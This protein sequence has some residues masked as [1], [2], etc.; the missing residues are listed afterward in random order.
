MQLPKLYLQA[1]RD[2]AIRRFHPWVFSGAI[3]RYEG[4]LSDGD[5]VAIDG[6]SLQ[7]L[8]AAFDAG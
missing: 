4:T 1:G 3:S 8:K 6:A 5:V 7:W 2:E